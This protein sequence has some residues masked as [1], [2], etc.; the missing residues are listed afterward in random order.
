MIPPKVGD[1]TSAM[2]FGS[3]LSFGVDVTQAQRIEA[4]AARGGCFQ[5][6]THGHE[7]FLLSREEAQDLI[8]ADAKNADVI[9]PFLIAEE[10][11]GRR[12]DYHNVLLLTFIQE[13]F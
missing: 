5:G 11:I 9:F 1:L 12:M 2:R 3:S 13:M 8:L 10:L 7:G 6:Q 4:N